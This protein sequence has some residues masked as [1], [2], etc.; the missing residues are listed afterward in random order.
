MFAQVTH[1]ACGHSQR[2]DCLSCRLA[3]GV[4]VA[5]GLPHV[6][7]FDDRFVMGS[8]HP[9]E[10][11]KLPPLVIRGQLD[12]IATLVIDDV[13]TSGFHMHEALTALR[14]ALVPAAGIAWIGG[15]IRS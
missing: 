5:L 6:K 15:V 7:A 14:S 1:V 10:N 12:Q 3:A 9:K 11:M 4:A 13:V 8:S 2:P